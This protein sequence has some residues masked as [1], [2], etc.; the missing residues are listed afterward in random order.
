[1]VIYNAATRE[2]TAKIVYYGPGL[3]GKTTNLKVLHDRLEPG[4]AGQAAEPPDADRPDDLLRPAPGRARRHQ[5]LQ[6]PLPARDRPRP[7]GLQ[8]DAPRRAEGRRRHRLRRRLAVDDAPEE[9]RELA[10]PQGQPE[11]PTTSPSRRSRSSSSTTSATSPTSSPSTR[12]RRRSAS[13]RTRSSRRSPRAGRGVTETFKLISKL[14]FVDLLRRLQGRRAEEESAARAAADAAE[15]AREDDL[16]TWKDSLL[17]RESQP[18][19]SRAALAPAFA[20]AARLGRGALRHDRARP[21][22]RRRGVALALLR[23]RAAGPRAGLAA[24]ARA[25]PAATIQMDAIAMESRSARRDDRGPAEEAPPEEEIRTILSEADAVEPEI[26]AAPTPAP[27]AGGRA[28]AE[29][30]VPRRAEAAARARS[31]SSSSACTRPTPAPAASARPPSAS[32][33]AVAAD[34]GPR[35]RDDRAPLRARRTARR[36]LEKGVGG[37]HEALAA[38]LRSASRPSRPRPGAPPSSSGSCERLESGASRSSRSGSR[39]EA[40]RQRKDTDDLGDGAAAALTETSA[41]LVERS[42]IAGAI[43]PA[44]G[45][46]ED[47]LRSRSRRARRDASSAARGARCRRPVAAPSEKSRGRWR[48]GSSAVPRSTGSSSRPSRRRPSSAAARPRTSAPRS[49]RCS[50][51]ASGA[52]SP[53]RCSSPRWSACASRSRSRSTT[54]PSAC[55]SVR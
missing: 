21:R 18:T 9:P 43:R 44:G 47:Q 15:A 27:R 3:C 24:G 4:T 55:A 40:G 51:S 33:Q 8:R 1:M 34:P 7:D 39:G 49:R 42:R 41:A 13:P 12:C 45:S 54:S 11:G 50:R 48:A 35:R 31:S 29:S 32:S 26:A 28:A 23:A 25:S 6:D 30:G 2:L 20:R 37:L 46:H 14:T 22:R 19:S 38:A 52:T 16:Q 17:K 53:T 36:A 5:G 10:E